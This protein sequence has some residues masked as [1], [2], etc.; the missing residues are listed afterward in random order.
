VARV[1]ADTA[2]ERP[3]RR[4]TAAILAAV[5]APPAGSIDPILEKRRRIARLVSLGQRVGY[6][7]FAL[8]TVV[9]FIGLKWPGALVANVVIVSLIVG[10][11]IL[12]PA[13]IFGYAVKAAER[14]D[15]EMAEAK[16]AKTASKQPR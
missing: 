1:P 11:I 4:D 2:R 10:S 15:R 16:A 5:S 8:A 3:I 6:G 14:E 7:L 13:I 12:C 9:F